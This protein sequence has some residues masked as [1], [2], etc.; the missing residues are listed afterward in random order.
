MCRKRRWS[1]SNARTAITSMSPGNARSPSGNWGMVTWPDEYGGRG[2]DLIEW[3]IFEEEYWA[4]RCARPRQPE[5]HLPARPDDHGIRHAGAEGALPHPDG[6]RRS[7]LGAGLV[8]TRRR[9]R[10]GGD[11]DE[12]DPGWRPLCHQRPEDLVEPRRLCRLG[13]RPVPHRPGQQAPQGAELHPVRPQ[14][15]RASPAARSASST[16]T[17]ALPSCSSTMCGC[18]WKTAWRAKAKAGTSPWPPPA[19]NAG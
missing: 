6:R 8:R 7:H 16:A 17:P 3:L 10:H 5:R 12:G 15:A 18:R 2:L 19:S 13:L 9:L 1:R 14:H 4:A 11:H